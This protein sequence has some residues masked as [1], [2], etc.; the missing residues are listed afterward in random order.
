MPA[1]LEARLE[2]LKE[3]Q[4]R[5]TQSQRRARSSSQSLSVLST[6]LSLRKTRVPAHSLSSSR[7]EYVAGTSNWREHEVGGSDFCGGVFAFDE[8]RDADFECS[9][10]KPIFHHILSDCPAFHSAGKRLRSCR[11]RRVAD[12]EMENTRKCSLWGEPSW[13]NGI[14]E[15][16]YW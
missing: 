10:C 16:T 15:V 3:W 11:T 1:H 2:R 4:I 7:K 9:G 13:E 5:R 6:A 8:H 14:S 12:P